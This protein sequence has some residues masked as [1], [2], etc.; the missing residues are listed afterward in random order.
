MLK[1]KQSFQRLLDQLL[2][3]LFYL[4]VLVTIALVCVVILWIVSE[5]GLYLGPGF[6]RLSTNQGDITLNWLK[7]CCDLDW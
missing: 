6:I 1:R 3:T 2:D 4:P 7:G 5:A